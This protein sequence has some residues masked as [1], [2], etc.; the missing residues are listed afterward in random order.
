M[1]NIVKLIN[2]T[3][4]NLK[5]VHALGW[6]GVFERYHFFLICK[7]RVMPIKFPVKSSEQMINITKIHKSKEGSSS[8]MVINIKSL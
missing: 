5:T 6:D 8:P 4:D 7:F 2:K 3:E 1:E